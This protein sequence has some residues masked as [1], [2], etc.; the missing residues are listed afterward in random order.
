VSELQGGYLVAVVD[1]DNKVSIRPVKMGAK[2]GDMWIVEDGLTPGER[3]VAEG[4]QRV[5]EGTQVNPKPYKASTLTLEKP[6][7]GK[8]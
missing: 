2:S 4:V 8:P 7:D 3:V 1:E 6:D 5:Q